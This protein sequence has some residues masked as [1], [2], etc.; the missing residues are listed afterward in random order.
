MPLCQRLYYFEHTEPATAGRPPLVL[1]HGAGG[2]HLFWPTEL[3]RLPGRTVLALDLPGHGRSAETGGMQRIA[4]YATEVLACLQALDVARVILVGHSMGGALALALA[5]SNPELLAGL[6]L[7]SSAARFQVNPALLA[8][9]ASPT[10]FAQAVEDICR[11]SFSSQADPHLLALARQRMNEVRPSVLH[12]DLLACA[13]VDFNENLSR[14]TCPTLVLCG[15][16]DRMTPLRQSQY[17]ADAIP[18]ARLQVF[19]GAGHMLMLEQ[20][21]LVAQAVG[22]FCN[23]LSISA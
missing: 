12:G 10:G 5:R 14:L 16:E 11:W 18:G 13:E 3:R 22:D 15:S 8:A 21:R 6:V 9:A 7:I 1:L 19:E 4:A 20:P 23:H 17:L 2:N